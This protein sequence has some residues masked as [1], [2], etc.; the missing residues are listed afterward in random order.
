MTSH[1][2]RFISAVL[3]AIGLLMLVGSFVSD[4]R[5]AFAEKGKEAVV[6]KTEDGK[7]KRKSGREPIS[8]VAKVSGAIGPATTDYIKMHTKAAEKLKAQVLILEMHTPGGLVTS[9]RDIN[10]II[11]ASEVPVVTYVS[12]PGSHAASAGTYILYASHVAAMAPG[13]NIGA[14]TPVSMQ[15]GENPKI[16]PN[17]PSMEKDGDDKKDKKDKKKS[18]KKKDKDQTSENP[19]NMS[20]DAMAHKAMNDAAAY[21]RGL[22]E[23]RGRNIE[24]AEQAVRKAATLTASEAMDK[25]VIEIVAENI[26]DLLEQLDGRKIEM[27]DG[28]VIL[29]TKDSTVIYKEPNWRTRILAI[30]TDPNIAFLLMT[31]GGY[32]LVYEFAN[33][34]TFVPGVI[35]VICIV[36]GLFAMNVLPV[37]YAGAVLLMLGMGFMAAE[38]F[39]P[40][41]GILGIGGAVAFALGGTI[42]FDTGTGDMGLSWWTIGVTTGMS[43]L[44]LTVLLA[45]AMKGVGN[46]ISTGREGL[47]NGEAEIL[48]WSGG[49]GEVRARGEIW[50]AVPDEPR[51]F[52]KGET[53]KITKIDGLKLVIGPMDEPQDDA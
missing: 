21:M 5:T 10:Q 34:G 42:L 22:A 26:E 52:R 40:S 39:I 30:I 24:W 14:A 44:L 9:T 43:F 46:P 37:N 12:P 33:P 23:M 13:T 25:G 1:R 18:S 8:Y 36:V 28:E 51:S 41:F 27:P 35:G 31:L 45:Y 32:G 48:K 50:Q 20:S 6:E 7:K 53:V 2:F 11:L 17:N 3:F 15:G 38:A 19:E 47:L 49:Q 4:V 16:S 29:D